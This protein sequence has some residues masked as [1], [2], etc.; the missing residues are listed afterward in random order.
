MRNIVFLLVLF[1]SSV[2]AQ[3]Y[4]WSIQHRTFITSICG[5]GDVAFD[6]DNA[7]YTTG[8]FRDTVDFD[9]DTTSAV[10]IS[11]RNSDLYLAKYTASGNYSWSI[12]IGGS[13]YIQASNVSTFNNNIFISGGFR[14]SVDFDPGSPVQY[15]KTTNGVYDA[16]I[17]KYDSAG[18]FIWV[19]PLRNTGP[20]GGNFITSMEIDGEGNIYIVGEYSG[21]FDFDP[22]TT[23]NVIRSA[24]G[25][26][27]GYIA[28]Y[29][30]D[31]EFKWLNVISGI[32]TS[33]VMDID[34]G[35]FGDLYVTGYFTDVCDFNP[36]GSSIKHTTNGASDIFV[37]KYDSS[38]TYIWSRSVGGTGRDGDFASNIEVSL[39]EV[40]FVSGT[41]RSKKIDFNPSGT[42]DTIDRKENY[43]NSFIWSLDKYGNHTWVK[44][45]GRPTQSPTQSTRPSIPHSLE[46]DHDNN[47]YLLGEI[48]LKEDFDP[49]H[50]TKLLSPAGL[51]SLSD[52]YLARYDSTGMILFG[53]VLG[54]SHYDAGR[55]IRIDGNG[56]IVAIGG[57]DFW[58][59]F[60]FGTNINYLYSAGNP[61][62]FIAKYS[63]CPDLNSNNKVSI[64][65]GERYKM[66]SGKWAYE[67]V[68]DTTT[69][70]SQNGCDSTIITELTVTEIDRTIR[71]EKGK[72]YSNEDSVSYQWFECDSSGFT[73]LNGETN[74]SFE[75]VTNGMYAVIVFKNG[76]VDTSGCFM[77]EWTGIDEKIDPSIEV[78]PNPTKGE[79][80]IS[81]ESP[82]SGSIVLTSNLGE[83]ILEME[84]KNEQRLT[85]DLSNSIS[86]GILFL[87]I[88][89]DNQP[90]VL[91]KIVKQ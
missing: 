84:F 62:P 53:D 78:F 40:V 7:V 75:P 77:V 69:I 39:N 25:F 13:D 29:S 19:K 17:A 20:Q 35:E 37:A 48:Y 88:Q 5:I 30:P 64:C 31:G 83:R 66:P 55:G 6:N 60:N 42:A 34:F 47:L 10:H 27:D 61:E 65:K 23:S 11:H 16:F 63:I 54:G 33:S 24:A 86:K 50:A 90:A 1:A 82:I 67:S 59:D 91:K 36:Q 21:S 9:P 22:S 57:Y 43:W 79:L 58:V 45:I 32:D 87:Y 49:S 44:S 26:K 89:A 3:Q 72:L 38:G 74:Q 85:L 52:I 51:N 68:V 80:N 14:D 76:C 71:A 15:L 8:S 28:K 12:S 46:V 41:Y 81:F 70:I 2:S 4:E 56:D 18:G 73:V